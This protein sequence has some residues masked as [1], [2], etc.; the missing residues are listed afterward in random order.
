MI[1]VDDNKKDQNKNLI[2]YMDRYC[3]T[4]EISQ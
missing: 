3:K 4:K 2:S 1:A